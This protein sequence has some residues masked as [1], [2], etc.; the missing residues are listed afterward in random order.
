MSDVNDE[1]RI[2]VAAFTSELAELIRRAAIEAVQ[3]ALG[4]GAG[5]LRLP[6]PARRGTT[7][8][9]GAATPRG[10]AQWGETAPS[11]R[12]G[13]KRAPGEKRPPEE[14][15]KLT[16]TLASYIKSNPGQRIEQIGTGLGTP[17]KELSLPVKK[18][19]RAKR[20]SSKGQKRATTYYPLN[21]GLVLVKKAKKP[22]EADASSN[23]TSA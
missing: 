16:E 10:E 15:A 14:L 3:E 4:N 17:T 20:I 7:G 19:L 6:P 23:E 21:K 13:R 1:V 5:G 18:L 22:A 9:K 12:L 2:R 11:R 8:A